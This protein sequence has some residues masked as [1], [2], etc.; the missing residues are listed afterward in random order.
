MLLVGTWAA[1]P[2]KEFQIEGQEGIRDAFGPATSSEKTQKERALGDDA[3]FVISVS[4]TRTNA[5]TCADETGAIQ[6]IRLSTVPVLY[7]RDLLAPLSL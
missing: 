1:I 4:F 2:A 6:F 7:D 3:A 5:I